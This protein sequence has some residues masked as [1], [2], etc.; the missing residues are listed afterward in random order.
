MFFVVGLLYIAFRS[1]PV[2]SWL[3]QQVTEYLSTELKTK[4]KVSGVDIAFFKTAIIEDLYVEDQSGDTMFYFRE[5]S[6]DYRTYKANKRLI[7]L[8]AIAIS[9]GKVYFGE[10]KGDSTDNYEFL[11]DYFDAGPRDPRKPKVIWTI[12]SDQLD[13]EDLRFD[14]F[15]DNDTAPDFM[16]FNYNQISFTDIQANASDFYLIDDSLHFTTNALSAKERCGFELKQL[17]AKTNIHAKGIEFDGFHL[18]SNQS[19]IKGDFK[20]LT[21]TWKDY[22][23]FNDQVLIKSKITEAS[24]HT[25]DLAFFSEA[26]QPYHF[27]LNLKGACE[28]PLSRLR[29]YSTEI[30]CL[31]N[32]NFKGD[33]SMTGLP[34]FDNTLLDFNVQ[35][36][37][38]N[39]H[40]L[41]V[42]SQNNI[43]SNF[44]ALGSI[45]YQGSFI[46]F[47]NDFVSFGDISTQIGKFKSDINIKYKDGLD[48]ASYSGTLKTDFF[49]IKAFVK[50]AQVDDVGFDVRIDGIGMSRDHYKIDLDGTLP[51]VTFRGHTFNDIKA[52]GQM[53]KSRF[54]GQA[55]FRDD[56]LNMDF[57]GEFRSDLKI[58]SAH[59]TADLHQVN[60]K[61]FGLDATDQWLK[62]VFNLDF[63]GQSI[64]DAEGSIVG[65]NV[66]IERNGQLVKVPYINL[67]AYEYNDIKELKLRSDIVD[68]GIK[69]DFKLK[70]LDVSIMHLMHQLIPSYFDMPST[71]LPQEDFVF[72]VDLKRPYDIT[73]LYVP[74][75]QLE[76]CIG[77]GN[78]NSSTQSLDFSLN[79]Q[80]IVYDQYEFKQLKLRANK[81]KGQQLKLAVDL[82]HF[83]DR[84]FI[85]TN[86]IHIESKV[87][88]NSVDY[89]FSGIDT[90]FK[91]GIRSVGDL[92]FNQ[93]SINIHLKKVQLSVADDV[94]SLDSNATGLIVGENFSLKDFVFRLKQESVAVDGALGPNTPQKLAISVNHFGLNTVNYFAKH[95]DL[96][97]LNGNANGN[98]YMTVQEGYNAFHSDIDVLNFSINGDTIGD[99]SVFTKNQSNSHLQHL[100]V[101]VDRGLLDSLRIEGDL[102]YKSQTQNYQLHAFLPPT[103]VK[104]FE[105]Y[106]EGIFKQLSGKLYTS[107]SLSITGTFSDPVI[108]GGLELKQ[109]N[110]IVDFLNTPLQFSSHID[111]DKNQLLVQ[112]FALTDRKKGSGM[113]KATFTHESFSAFKMDL[114]LMNLKQFHVL[115]TAKGD[116]D[117]FYGQGYASGNAQ[118]KGAFESLDLAVQAKTNAGTKLYIPISEGEASSFPNYV[119][120]KS[121]RKKIIKEEAS[122]FPLHSL[123]L[124]IEANNDADV[125][126][127]FDEILGD[128]ITG[129]GHG[130][131]KLEMNQSGDFFMFGNYIVDKGRYL[132]TAFDLYNKPFNIRPGGS[133]TWYGDPLD[134]KL[135][136]VAYNSETTS[137]SPL[138]TAVALNSNFNA[139]TAVQAVTVE[140]ELYLKGNL[141]LP[142]VSFGLNFP[143]LQ[144]EA[145]NYTSSLSPIINRIKSDKEE[146]NRQVFSLLLMKK[147]LPPMFA[148]SEAGLTNAGSTALSSAGTD[149]LSN[150]LSNWLNKIDPN[151]KV[152]VIYK[153]GSITLP[154]EY[155]LLLSSKFLNDKLTF[156]GSFSNYSSIPNINLEYKLTKKGNVKIKAYTRSSF[157]QVNTTSLSTPITTNGVGVV[158]TKE[159]NMLR[160]FKFLKRKGGKKK[161]H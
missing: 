105:P 65:E 48:K 129:T 42:L 135:N 20:L 9:G 126:I 57:D 107:D 134:A 150:Q 71:K 53:S 109:V 136:I 38:S 4:V 44:S 101:Y 70:L 50:E 161:R 23:H 30:Q 5:L 60:L 6:I 11:L 112:P 156:D 61:S 148:Q 69:G 73:S 33:W 159:F 74:K 3:A 108:K 32:T 137:P 122:D 157:N 35:Q 117:L 149:L 63:V 121:N 132:F 27:K 58:P 41:N 76:P 46:G 56:N 49:K 21:N 1:K 154:A 18:F 96:P 106:L 110:C 77:K 89:A 47:Y 158:Y 52:K 39:Y 143:K 25:D 13:L 84:D 86:A 2:Q 127:I 99:L 37:K 31:Q 130:D 43:P 95:T 115:N 12:H 29:G 128:K 79:N 125:E 144:T 111:L 24:I 123:V 113:A 17:Q 153:N 102:D 119:H 92:Q 118:I 151:W 26:I 75:L 140:S 103:D 7:E 139:N 94:W 8:N 88:D 138:L 66:S 19:E 40:D 62:G 64:D 85:H 104:L 45:Q 93:D 131:L 10:H 100:K 90:G 98:V 16:P 160:P 133:I 78:Y 68:A 155:G 34:N 67:S 15:Q 147:F 141:F 91:I 28:G 87:Y 146:V 55:T 97:H 142:E 124:D 152:N 72:E 36:F 80:L 59:F 22:N 83:T 116:N 114:E 120:F 82:G 54:A 14:Y 81:V 51:H 145:G